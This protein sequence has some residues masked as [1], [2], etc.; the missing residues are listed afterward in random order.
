M[1]DDPT[2]NGDLTGPDIHGFAPLEENPP[3]LKCR[4]TGTY[5]FHRRSQ[6][7]RIAVV[8]GMCFQCRGKGYMTPADSART[9]HYWIHRAAQGDF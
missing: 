3:C 7:G 8:S 1:Q 4:G 6:D 9:A 2:L 5:S